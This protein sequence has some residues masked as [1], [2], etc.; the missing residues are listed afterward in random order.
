M[1]RLRTIATVT[2]LAAAAAVIAR[3]RPLDHQADPDHRPGG[4]RVAGGIL[5]NH[6]GAYDRMSRLLLGGLFRG[7]ARDVAATTPAGGRVLEVGS[8]P[9][10]LAIRLA[11]EH[12]LNVVGID[13]DPEMID[14]AR[15][16]ADEAGGHGRA[17][18]FAVA[19]VAELPFEDD[20][21]DVV[22]STMSMHHWTE[23]ERG[24]AEIGRVLRPGGRAL[25]WDIRAGRSLPF[26]PP[27]P[28][29]EATIAGTALE[30]VRSTPWR[31]P[32]RLHVV[33]RIELVPKAPAA[34]A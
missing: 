5:M 33:Q 3:H 29:P 25:I 7:I 15:E 28:D 26:H 6:R 12:G 20:S 9:G 22:L 13:L 23:P 19:D 10:H 24:L 18:E 30:L 2:G 11:A 34:A 4:H 8:G 21:F 32:G 1:S 14:H 27:A 31:W 17:P 16:N